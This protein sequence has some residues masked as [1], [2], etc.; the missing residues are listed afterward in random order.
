M[1]EVLLFILISYLL[2]SI[3]FGLIIASINKIDIRSHG[4][5]NIGATNVYRV[6]GK[7]WGLLTFFLDA[8]KGFLPVYYFLN[9]YGNHQ[10]LGVCCGLAAILGHTF[11]V[12][13]KFRGGKGVATSAGMLFGIAPLPVFIGL[14]VWIIIMFLFRF[15]S[16][17]SITA[18]V[19]ISVIICFSDAYSIF[20]KYL[21]TFISILI[22]WLHRE[23]ISRLIKGTENRFG[24]KGQK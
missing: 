22:I 16:L 24:K 12:Y 15:V 14:L 11:P 5:G 17:A 21:I 6:I 8:M 4:S 13:I 1:M 19:V 10:H 23:N 7:F 18:S 9:F 20:T 2:G 3:P